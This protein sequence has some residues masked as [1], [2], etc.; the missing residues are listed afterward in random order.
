MNA[1]RM[2]S[3]HIPP[4]IKNLI[5]INVLVYLAESTLGQ[6]AQSWM[7]NLFA[8]HDVHSIFFKP[9]QL[10]TYLFLHGSWSHIL[11]NMLFLWMFGTSLEDHWGSK[12]FLI[13]Y[14][15]AGIGAAVCH[16]VVL[17]MEM[18]PL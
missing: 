3:F 4:V 18:A 8:L 7:F 12:R 11:Y 17:Y 1:F 10:I 14:I 6:G 16:M 9:H 15:V 13:F 5:I 2:G